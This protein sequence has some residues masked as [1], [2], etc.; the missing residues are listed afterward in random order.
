MNISFALQYVMLALGSIPDPDVQRRIMG[1]AL[2]DEVK[3]QDMMYPFTGVADRYS[4][5]PKCL[6]SLMMRVR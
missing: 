1:W 2:S 6:L 5:H 3:M 4:S